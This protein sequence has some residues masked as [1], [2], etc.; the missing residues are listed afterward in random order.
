MT[1]HRVARSA[2]LA[3]AAL[4][5]ASAAC[6]PRGRPPAVAPPPSPPLAHP[7]PAE[8]AP[9]FA[10]LTPSAPAHLDEDDNAVV[11]SGASSGNR[12]AT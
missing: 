8:H 10:P 9:A 11:R 4:L 1:T 3:I 7:A 2:V 12:P 6:A 5:F